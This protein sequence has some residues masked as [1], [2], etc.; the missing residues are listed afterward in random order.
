MKYAVI[1]DIH[2]NLEALEAVLADIKKERVDKC[3]CVGDIVGYGA[4][5]HECIELVRKHC[6]VCVAGNHDFATIER[7]NIEFF[8]QYARQAT[9]WTRQNITEDDRKYLESLPL[10]ADVDDRFTLVHGTLYAPALFDYI[11]TTFDAYLSLQVLQKPLCFVGHSHVPI[12]FF[13][14]DAVTYSTDS[15]IE[16]KEG[17][18]AV[19]NVGSVGQPRDDDPRAAYAIYDTEKNLVVIKRVEYDVEKAIKKIR[20]AGLPEILGERLRYGR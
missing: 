19:I 17:V 9:L 12:S 13:L 4:N 11:Q 7:T 14:D 20:D 15:V 16:L 10:V 1:S 6:P 2:A 18:K 5:P 8:N 3:V